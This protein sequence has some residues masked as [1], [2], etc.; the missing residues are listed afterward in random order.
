MRIQKAAE[1]ELFT[2][3]S[4]N[5]V[6]LLKCTIAV[7]PNSRLDQISKL[8]SMLL[9]LCRISSHVHEIQKHFP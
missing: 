4:W 8:K 9:N 5:P 1:Q 7:L 6:W 3:Q 2:L